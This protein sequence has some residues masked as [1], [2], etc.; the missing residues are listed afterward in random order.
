MVIRAVSGAEM[1]SR[2]YSSTRGR[3]IEPSTASMNSSCM[4]SGRRA[5]CF[6]SPTERAKARASGGSTV[7]RSS[8]TPSGETSNPARSSRSRVSPTE[9]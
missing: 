1:F 3:A 5:R 8:Q 4:F 7:R 6:D 2:T 9:A